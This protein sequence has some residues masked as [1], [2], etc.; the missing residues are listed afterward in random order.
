[1]TLIL[2]GELYKGPITD[3]GNTPI[4]KEN[5]MPFFF[6]NL[7]ALFVISGTLEYHGYSV[8]A[9]CDRYG[10]FLF[11]FNIGGLLFC[12]FLY[13][14]GMYFPSSS[15]NGSSG[16]PIFDFYW[17]VE[18]YPRIGKLDLKLMTN[19]RWGIIDYL[20]F[21]FIWFENSFNFFLI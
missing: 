13:V 1:M 2:P 5:G 7:I 10:E 18:L 19:C 17:G 20:K 15:D 12:L 9:I 6:I 16:N 4:Y 14:K 21:I 3:K 11:L 8:T